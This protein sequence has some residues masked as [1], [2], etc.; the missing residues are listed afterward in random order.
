MSPD[1]PATKTY[2]ELVKKLCDH[3]VPKP[4]ETV[5]RF[6]FHSRYRR[7]GES[8]ADFV[9]ELRKLAESCNFGAYLDDMLRDPLVCGVADERIQRHLLLESTLTLEKAYTNAVAQEMASRHASFQTGR[10]WC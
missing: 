5:Q 2:S 9:F 7:T 1:K 10:H 6:K 3:F 4:T 8:M